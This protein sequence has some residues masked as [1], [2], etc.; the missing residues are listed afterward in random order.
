MKTSQSRLAHFL[1]LC[2]VTFPVWPTA[3]NSAPPT[4]APTAPA[5]EI[6]TGPEI[7]EF[8]SQRSFQMLVDQ[9]SFGPRVPSSEAHERCLNYIVQNLKPYVD[10]TVLQSFNYKD[11][12]RLKTIRLTNILGVINP[13]ATDKVMLCAHWDSRPTADED[14]NIANRN[15]PIPGADDGASGV[16]VLLQLAKV[17]HQQKPKVGVILAF[18]DGEDWGPDDDH[19]Y[20]GAKYFCNHIGVLTPNKAVLIDMI[21]N[22]GVT[23]PKEQYSDLHAPS[24]EQEVYGDAWQLGYT[25]SFPDISG[26]DIIDDHVS[27]NEAGIPTIDLIDFNYA[28]WHTLQ[29]TPDKCSPDS[30]AIIGRTL[31]LF[32]YDQSP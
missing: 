19:M 24:L 30:L 13:D 15:T 23:I 9:C 27:M 1:L 4:S 17:F 6:V 18:W 26:S 10:T 16:A 20:L 21:G 25:A 29:D 22:K 14:F 7:P 32:V 3:C 8:D 28:Y 11:T 12:N 2:L 5:T 31:E